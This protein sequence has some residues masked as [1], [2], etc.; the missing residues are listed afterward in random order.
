MGGGEEESDCDYH[1]AGHD[2]KYDDDLNTATDWAS[3]VRATSYVMLDNRS[4]LFH[5]RAWSERVG[6]LCMS[7]LCVCRHYMAGLAFH[8]PLVISR[9][10][11][12][13]D[14]EPSPP[15]RMSVGAPQ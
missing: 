6:V 11:T 10:A 7:F 14:E 15:S 9:A 4:R 8:W 2:D 13:A 5:D 1:D 12:A 3:S